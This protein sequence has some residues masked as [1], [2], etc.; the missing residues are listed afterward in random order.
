[1]IASAGVS[2]P[3][4][5]AEGRG[6]FVVGTGAAPFTGVRVGLV[7]ARTLALAWG[8]QLS[9]VC[10]LD[11]LGAAHGGEVTVVADA[12]RHE[13]YWARFSDGSRVDG[14]HVA[15]PG[16]VPTEVPVIGRGASL[17]PD[18]FGEAADPA[19]W[20]PDPAWLARVAARCRADG[21]RS[22]LAEP[23]YLRRPDVHGVPSS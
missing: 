7:T 17:Y 15:A 23:L 2:G 22:L 12:R 18:V 1:V 21:E 4:H 6:S 5:W 9:G 11:A 3:A 10:S 13:V 8:A 16:E 19:W 20:D 14:P